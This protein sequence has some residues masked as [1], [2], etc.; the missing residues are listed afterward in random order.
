MPG[1]Q[2]GKK[3]ENFQAQ[4]GRWFCTRNTGIFLK[5]EMCW[6]CCVSK[7]FAQR[8][9]VPTV[10]ARKC[11]FRNWH[12]SILS[13]YH[14]CEL[15][16]AV[17]DALVERQKINGA[18]ATLRWGQ[19]LVNLRRKTTSFRKI[20]FE[21]LIDWWM[22]WWIDG[23]MDWWTDGL[24][25]WWIDGLMDWWTDWWM[26]CLIDWL[27]VL[28]GSCRLLVSCVHS[29]RIMNGNQVPYARWTNFGVYNCALCV[30]ELR[31][32]VFGCSRKKHCHVPDSCPHGCY[33][34]IQNVGLYH[35]SQ[36][37]WFGTICIRVN[38]ML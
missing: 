37:K 2:A 11:S 3:T 1:L 24:M 10:F 13:G 30:G 16:A 20:L 6:W 15:G 33:A 25:D 26:D 4:F 22:D 36:I 23:L 8:I 19:P 18:E 5:T 21:W 32:S 12:F 34:P 7:I 14:P 29:Y 35:D 31:I 38:L 17:C 27:I 9:N 28:I